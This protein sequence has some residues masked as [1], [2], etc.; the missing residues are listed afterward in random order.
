MSRFGRRTL[1]LAALL[2]LLGATLCSSAPADR[3]APL[4]FGMS[5]ALSGPLAEIGKQLQQGVQAGLERANRAGGIHG[6]PLELIALD[7][8]YEPTRSV[9]NMQ[10]LLG[11]HQVLALIGNLGTP[12]AIASIPIAKEHRTLFFAPFT[13]AGVLR[14]TPP[15]RYLI[16]YRA[17]Y[18]EE[19]DSMV[20]ALVQHGG[21]RPEEIGFFTQRDGYGDAGYAG[22]LQALKDRG[23]R[24]ELGVLHVRYQRNTL[25]VENALADVLLSEPLPRA[26]IMVGTYAPCAKFI[27][28]A[29]DAGLQSLFLHVSFVG[30]ESLAGALPVNTRGVLMSQVVP[31]PFSS[32]LPLVREYRADLAQLDSEWQ[33]S[34]VSLEG[35]IAAR[36]LLKALQN[37]SPPLNREKIIQALEE[38]ENFDIGL[39][40]SLLLSPEEHQ[41]SHQVWLTQLQQGRFIPFDWR[42]I[43]E[44]L[45]ARQGQP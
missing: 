10:T 39:G 36:I 31:D 27:R 13:G 41:A 1:L 22:G 29:R 16:N 23:L 4:R 24:N 12:T 14:R 26:I 40:I 20:R 5:T 45:P 19:I 35:Y 8:G 33:P 37:S 2:H 6:R 3:P 28:L 7:D 11:D 25:A 34:S 9:P 32:P 15:D 21:L 38:L 44:L 18:A 17:S 30:S 42:R 43:G